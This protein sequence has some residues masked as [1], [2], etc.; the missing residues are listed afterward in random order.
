MTA[1][2][3]KDHH[4]GIPGA[5]ALNL[6]IT[7][8]QIVGGVLSNSIALLSDAVHNLG[9]SLSLILAYIAGKM[10]KKAADHRRTFGYARAEVIAALLNTLILSGITVFLF[11]EAIRRFAEPE[12]VRSGLLILF[13]FAGLVA[14]VG[15]MLLL[16]HGRKGSINVRAAYVHLLGDALSSLIVIA[17]GIA[18]YLFDAMWIDPF[19]TIIIGLYILYQA[20]PIFRESISILMLSAP[21]EIPLDQLTAS[22]RGLS[23]VKNIHHIHLWRP[24]DHSIHL[25][26]HVDLE[27]DIMVSATE[28]IHR[29]A[30][31]IMAEKFG[32]HHLTLQ[33]ECDFCESKEIIHQPY[34]LDQ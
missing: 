17:G 14:N 25:E 20:Y 5:I 32:I 22:L 18:M 10:G 26:A 9:D 6:A 4:Q 30:E 16:R 21:V 19:L 3:A 12:P 31:E 34:H 7:L 24:D 29:Q 8:L 23:G 1:H 11:V 2:S 27:K 15:G 13:A 33:M 28:A